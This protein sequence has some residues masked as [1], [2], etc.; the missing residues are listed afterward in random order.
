MKNFGTLLASATVVAAH[1]IVSNAT[2]DNKVYDFYNPF[3]DPYM[4]PTPSRISRKIDGNGPVQDVTNIDIQCGANGGNGTTPA[5]LNAKAT[6][7]STVK[8]H[9]TLWPTS[10][11]GPTITYMAKCPSTG[12]QDYLPGDKA[13]W[14]K[15]QEQGRT[16]TS[17]VW[18]AVSFFFLILHYTVQY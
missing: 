5:K 9:W 10:H 2:I 12:C 13:V 15:V 8:L 16:G 4:N 1:G 7:G 14:F 6:A 18:G 3:T 17:D 11:V